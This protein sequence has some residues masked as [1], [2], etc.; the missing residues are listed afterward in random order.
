M[1]KDKRGVFLPLYLVFLTVFMCGLVITMY[2]AQ[3]KHVQNSIVSPYPLLNLQMER[4]R[5]EMQE[6]DLIN[7]SIKSS[8][9]KD[10]SVLKVI[11]CDSFS[12]SEFTNWLFKDLVYDNRE[13]VEKSFVSS[14]SKKAFCNNIYMFSVSG[15]LLRVERLK[16]N[17]RFD[18]IPAISSK[19]VIRF[20]V[21]IDYEFSKNYEISIV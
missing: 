20:P 16:L 10:V 4:E 8:G 18:L 13:N 1:M 9:G 19:E 15:G 7:E 17:K 11:F 21:K 12:T 2:W 6:R 3:D 5:F 14:A